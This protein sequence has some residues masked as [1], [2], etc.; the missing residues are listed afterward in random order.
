MNMHFNS[1][2]LSSFP[3]S[4]FPLPLSTILPFYFLPSFLL[5][6]NLYI[7]SIVFILI[8]FIHPH[9]LIWFNK[10]LLS[11]HYESGHVLMLRIQTND[12]MENIC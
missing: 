5:I 10:Y 11:T 9:L 6:V 4:L 8:S 1:S 2:L 12:L 7:N 3:S